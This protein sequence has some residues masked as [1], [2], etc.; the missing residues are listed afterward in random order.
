MARRVRPKAFI[1]LQRLYSFFFQKLKVTAEPILRFLWKTGNR[2]GK[3]RNPEYS[4][5]NMQPRRYPNSYTLIGQI[6]L[7][8]PIELH[9]ISSPSVLWYV[10]SI[11]SIKRYLADS[12]ILFYR[13]QQR[14]GL[15]SESKSQCISWPPYYSSA[16]AP[17]T[18]LTLLSERTIPICA[19]S[20]GVLVM[21]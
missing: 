2:N 11:C 1:L 15:L 12:I 13:F 14:G 20:I 3:Y 21:K 9:K 16:L 18:L 7:L 6:W 19:E 4:G 10:Q 8:F 5:R 17:K